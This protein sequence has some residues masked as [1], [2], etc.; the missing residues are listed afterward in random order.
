MPEHTHS[1]PVGF[2]GIMGH[3]KDV[4]YQEN[5]SY[6]A[7]MAVNKEKTLAVVDFVQVRSRAYRRSLRLPLAGLEGKAM[8]REK[9]SGAV[10]SGAAWMYGGL[11]LKDMQADFYS[12]LV[13]LERVH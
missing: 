1:L 12:E 4:S 3:F 9:A 13:V 8:Y 10:R 11:L 5:N 7:V 2:Q 6:D